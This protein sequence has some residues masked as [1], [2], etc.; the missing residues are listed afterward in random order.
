MLWSISL[1]TLMKRS[2]THP[3]TREPAPLKDERY[4][5]NRA[6]VDAFLPPRRRGGPFES[7]LLH[8]RTHPSHRGLRASI[9]P[10]SKGELIGKIMAKSAPRVVRPRF[11]WHYQPVR[12]PNDQSVMLRT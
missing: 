7:T 1:V 6:V 4:Q 9:S 2:V 8:Y 11:R 12:Q 3:V 10:A 5:G